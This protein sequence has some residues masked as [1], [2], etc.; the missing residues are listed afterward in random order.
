MSTKSGFYYKP[1]QLPQRVSAIQLWVEDL[2]I[3]V[4]AVFSLVSSTISP[5]S[6]AEK[7][8]V[9]TSSGNVDG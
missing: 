7:V 5:L 3:F 9:Q 4:T 2:R 8:R 1:F 6:S